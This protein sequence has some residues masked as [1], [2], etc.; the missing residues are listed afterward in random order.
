VYLPFQLD[1]YRGACTP[2]PS[3]ARAFFSIM[4][5]S[6][7][8]I[9]NYRSVVTP[10]LSFSYRVVLSFETTVEYYSIVEVDIVFIYIKR[11]FTDK[12]NHLQQI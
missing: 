11:T 7:P 5:E 6:T 9:G 8:E 2:S 12:K 4:M 10:L 3:P 1:G